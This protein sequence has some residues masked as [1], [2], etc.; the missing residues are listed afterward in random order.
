LT[1]NLWFHGRTFE[2]FDLPTNEKFRP[3]TN[4]RCEKNEECEP[5]IARRVWFAGAKSRMNNPV[6][7]RRRNVRRIKHRITEVV[8]VRARRVLYQRQLNQ[9]AVERGR[10]FQRFTISGK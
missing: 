8:R 3:C 4:F 2:N 1:C 5:A 7:R 6:Q 9:W 10:T